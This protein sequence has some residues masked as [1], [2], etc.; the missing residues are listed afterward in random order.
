MAENPRYW[1]RVQGGHVFDGPTT[2]FAKAFELDAGQ[3]LTWPAEI[4]WTV[5]TFAANPTTTPPGTPGEL[6]AQLREH[7]TRAATRGIGFETLA[8]LWRMADAVDGGVGAAAHHGCA[9]LTLPTAQCR[10]CQ[11]VLEA[12]VYGDDLDR[13]GTVFD[14]ALPD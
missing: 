13:Q 5:E 1:I 12:E 10:E 4:G 9:D 7:A 6:A 11:I 14:A 3:E 8:Y 2:E